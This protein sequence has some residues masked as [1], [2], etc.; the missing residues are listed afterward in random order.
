MLAC[1]DRFPDPCW[2]ASL[3]VSGMYSLVADVDNKLNSL[4]VQAGLDHLE[5]LLGQTPMHVMDILVLNPARR[6]FQSTGL[7]S[8]PGNELYILESGRK[9]ESER[10]RER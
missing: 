8:L 9:P 3:S 6:G 7:Y 10:T 1:V 5:T 4:S 2:P